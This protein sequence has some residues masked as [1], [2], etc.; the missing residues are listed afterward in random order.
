MI[1]N[2]ESNL[3]MLGWLQQL[4]AQQHAIGGADLFR[5]RQKGR[6]AFQQAYC[7]PE[8]VEG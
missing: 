7:H 2:Q 8:P 6:L 5:P 4:T 1:N 3:L